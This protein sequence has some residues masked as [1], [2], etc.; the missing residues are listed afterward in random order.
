VSKRFDE[1]GG[2]GLIEALRQTGVNRGLHPG[3]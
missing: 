3:R 1:P 2:G